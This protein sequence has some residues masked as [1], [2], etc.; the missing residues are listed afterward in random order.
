MKS[1]RRAR[2][3]GGLTSRITRQKMGSREEVEESRARQ[4]S[5][6]SKETEKQALCVLC[7]APY[8]LNPK[9]NPCSVCEGAQTKKKKKKQKKKGVV[10][11]RKAG[12]NQGE[13]KREKGQIQR[14]IGIISLELDR[15]CGLPPKEQ[16]RK[17]YTVPQS[18][19]S[20]TGLCLCIDNY[21]TVGSLVFLH[22][23]IALG[24]VF[25]HAQD[26]CLNVTDCVL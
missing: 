14:H 11:Q 2:K 24:S 5:P 10:L 25:V 13:G 20:Q 22:Q 12:H 17:L 1:K 18:T 21:C 26:P 6:R 9:N 4:E 7:K 16:T 19:K 15:V 23:F 8:P 3:G